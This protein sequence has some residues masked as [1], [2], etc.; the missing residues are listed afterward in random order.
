VLAFA[1]HQNDQAE[2]VLL[3]LLRGT[4][5][6][7]AAAMQTWRELGVSAQGGLY[8]WRPWLNITR[9]QID[10]YITRNELKYV[11]DPSNLNTQFARNALR[12]NVMPQIEQ[13]FPSARLALTRFAQTAAQALTEID[14]LAQEDLANCSQLDSQWGATVFV[15]QLALLSPVRQAWVLRLWLK[16]A[17]LRAPSQARLRQM[18]WQLLHAKSDA[19]ILLPYQ[20]KVVRRFKESILLISANTVSRLPLISSVQFESVTA[21]DAPGLPAQ[22]VA[23]GGFE[24]RSRTGAERLKMAPNRPTR[25]LKNLFQELGVAPWQRERALCLYQHSQLLWVS[26]IGFDCRFALTHGERFHPV[27]NGS[28]TAP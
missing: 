23:Q 24:F 18:L 6:S 12:H 15:S 25:T 4:G 27:V 2:T 21:Q 1:Q 9:D 8:A 22:L 5:L 20:G 11:D 10:D 7:G 26:G 16:N 3:Q 28:I 17:G 19:Q 14:L 13:Y